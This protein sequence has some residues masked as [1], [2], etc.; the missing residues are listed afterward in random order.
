MRKPF[1]SRRI[2]AAAVLTAVTLVGGGLA[3]APAAS[4]DTA[5]AASP[6]TAAPR[7]QVTPDGGWSDCVTVLDN[8]GELTSATKAV[9]ISTT[10]LAVVNSSHAY[11]QCVFSLS[12]LGVNSRVA[13]TACTFAA[14][15]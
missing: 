11:T 15:G 1:S 14:F 8:F 12:G 3:M 9:C 2:G 5:T 4:A 10:L 7:S 6:S 13:I